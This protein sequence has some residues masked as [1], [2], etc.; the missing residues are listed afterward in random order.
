MHGSRYNAEEFLAAVRPRVA[1]VSVGAHNSYGHP[2]QHVLDALAEQGV[3]VL[4]T[5]LNGDIAVV[6]PPLHSRWWRAETRCAVP[7][8]RLGLVSQPVRD[9]KSVAHEPGDGSVTLCT[10]GLGGGSGGCGGA[11]VGTIGAMPWC[12]G[13]CGKA[14]RAGWFRLG[15]CSCP[16]R[17][18]VPRHPRATPARRTGRSFSGE[19]HRGAAPGVHGT[20]WPGVESETEGLTAGS[21]AGSA[22]GG[23]ADGSVIV[24]I[25]SSP[26]SSEPPCITVADSVTAYRANSAPKVRAVGLQGVGDAPA[27]RSG[28]AIPRRGRR[29]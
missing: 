2:S 5:D 12:R 17:D 26:V 15:G 24:P 16:S 20:A 3:S 8:P 22:M 19:P 18:A 10:S 9:M 27:G 23:L 21:C 28:D 25:S 11:M 4:R 13:D 7:E 6:G 14:S 1:I 29:A